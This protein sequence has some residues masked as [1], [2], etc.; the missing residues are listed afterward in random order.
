M[1]TYGDILRE[2]RLFIFDLDGTVYLGSNPFDFAI[3][4][5]ENLRKAGRRVLFFT[6]NASHTRLHYYT[7]L[8]GMG[9]S[10]GQDEIMTAG[11]V[12]AE[13]LLRRRAEKT[14]YLVGTSELRREW[15]TRG[16]RFISEDDIS[17]GKRA[18][19]VVSSFD[20]ELT[21]EKLKNAVYM[22]NGGAEYFCTHPDYNCPT[23]SG[24]IPDSGSIAALI[25]ASTG[26]VPK[27]FGKPYSETVEMIKEVTHCPF[28][29]ICVVGDRLYT[30]IALGANNGITT[31]LVLTGETKADDI[32]S[33]SITP[34]IVFPSLSEANSAM[35]GE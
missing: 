18:D 6:N 35:F 20:T 23:E 33:S 27:Y 11:D 2:K 16:I 15:R 34:D 22:I 21:Y 12:T 7:K 5:V 19:V 10:P 25:T 14:V 1:S 29:D 3:Q 9:F 28:R 30:D 17:I 4:F 8:S 13:Y 31:M 32:A 24:P 26:V